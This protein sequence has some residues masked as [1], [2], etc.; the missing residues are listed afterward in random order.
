MFNSAHIF[1]DSSKGCN[2]P[3][4]LLY[5]INIRP[6]QENLKYIIR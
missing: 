2:V 5:R 6:R 3:Y 4:S 1:V